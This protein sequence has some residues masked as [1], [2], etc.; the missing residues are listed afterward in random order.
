MSYHQSLKFLQQHSYLHDSIVDKIEITNSTF[1]NDK[2][3]IVFQ[4]SG[5][6]D[7][8]IYLTSQNNYKIKI[9]L[10]KVGIM[11]IH[12]FHETIIFECKLEEKNNK[13]LFSLTGYFE[14]S[15]TWFESED[16]QIEIN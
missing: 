3:H 12:E 5:W 1:I 15:H 6:N 4:K 2:G 9:K 10:I 8:K 7:I 11:K 14:S 13:I 16:I